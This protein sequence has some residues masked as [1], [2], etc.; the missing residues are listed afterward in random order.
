MQKPTVYTSW[1]IEK[2]L[3][4]YF[5]GATYENDLGILQLFLKK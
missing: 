5:Q 1:V 4:F 2:Y 3:S